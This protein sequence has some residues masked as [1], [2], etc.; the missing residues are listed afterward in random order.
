MKQYSGIIIA[1]GSIVLIGAAVTALV[2]EQYII[3]L[4][5]LG[6]GS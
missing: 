5:I 2:A 3:A 4:S 1:F 6:A